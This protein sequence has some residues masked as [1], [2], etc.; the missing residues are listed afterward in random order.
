MRAEAAALRAKAAEMEG[1]GPLVNSLPTGPAGGDL[2]GTYP[3]PKIR[4]SAI[5]SATL[6]NGTL[7]GEDFGAGSIQPSDIPDQTLGSAQ[8]QNGAIGPLKLAG[9][10]VGAG[11]LTGTHVLVSQGSVVEPGEAVIRRALCPPGELLLDGGAEWRTLL[12][13]GVPA[14]DNV[15][16]TASNPDLGNS[17]QW[18][19]IGRNGTGEKMMLVAFSLCLNGS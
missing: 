3:N 14:R 4:A 5:T 2:T 6:L 18:D 1:R 15:F 12:N 16:T 19:V 7:R 10:S 11:E 8:I 9:S 17:S 13:G